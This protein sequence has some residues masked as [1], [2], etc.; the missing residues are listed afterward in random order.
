MFQFA[1]QNLQTTTWR[2]K[3]RLLGEMSTTTNNP[4]LPLPGGFSGGKRTT[5]A[6]SKLSGSGVRRGLTSAEWNSLLKIILSAMIIIPFI[7][8]TSRDLHHLFVIYTFHQSVD[9]T[10]LYMNWRTKTFHLEST[11]V[12]SIMPWSLL[13]I[14]FGSLAFVLRGKRMARNVVLLIFLIVLVRW[15]YVDTIAVFS[16][17]DSYIHFDAKDGVIHRIESYLTP[18]QANHLVDLATE[19]QIKAD[20]ANSTDH[21]WLHSIQFDHP[22]HFMPPMYDT[23]WPWS[24]VIL[25]LLGLAVSSLNYR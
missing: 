4:R 13:F 12:N 16:P 11:S 17:M 6:S 7:I 1:H 18:K 2:P 20:A 24:Y 25:F 15:T 9:R 14:F 3:N 10:V 8:L 23:P 19:A 21:D 22:V 5:S